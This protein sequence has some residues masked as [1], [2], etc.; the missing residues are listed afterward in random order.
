[1]FFLIVTSFGELKIV[2]KIIAF[3]AQVRRENEKVKT[4][5]KEPNAGTC[6]KCLRFRANDQYRPPTP[7]RLNCRVESRTR[8]V[9]VNARVGSRDP[10]YNFLRC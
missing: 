6:E 2:K 5:E 9:G 1:V 8:V 7:T 10:V 4:C 3:L